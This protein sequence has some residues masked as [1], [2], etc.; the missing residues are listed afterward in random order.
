MARF[1]IGPDGYLRVQKETTYGTPL[2][3]SMSALPLRGEYSLNYMVSSIER[4]NLISS[5][6][7]QKPAKGRV[8]GDFEFSTDIIP[9]I[10]GQSFQFFWVEQVLALL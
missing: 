1:G 6:Y 7:P 2:T 4:S 5:R 10:I 9:S 3:N 8:V